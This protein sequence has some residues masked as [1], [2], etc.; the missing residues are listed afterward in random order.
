MKF[1]FALLSV[2]PSFL[3][4]AGNESDRVQIDLCIITGSVL[5]GIALD[6]TVYKIRQKQK[7]VSFMQWLEGFGENQVN[8]STW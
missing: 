8:E 4:Y 1:Y 5:I 2:L 7:E 3:L 6:Y